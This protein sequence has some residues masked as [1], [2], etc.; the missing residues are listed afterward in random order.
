MYYYNN[1]DYDYVQSASQICVLILEE[2]TLSSSIKVN[3]E[4][5]V[6]VLIIDSL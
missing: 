4:E 6:N 5:F 1:T 2:R 3:Y